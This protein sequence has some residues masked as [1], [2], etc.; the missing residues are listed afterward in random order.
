MEEGYV[1]LCFWWR[2]YLIEHVLFL[3]V[4]QPIPRG[5]IFGLSESGSLLRMHLNL[6]V[7]SNL[8]ETS[9]CVNWVCGDS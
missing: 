2:S 3:R 6:L 8:S 7:E 5:N 4:R 1:T 9:V